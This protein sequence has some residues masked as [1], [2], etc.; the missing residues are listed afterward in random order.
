MFKS[1]YEVRL[2]C[3]NLVKG[4]PSI[5][6][7]TI[8]LSNLDRIFNHLVGDAVL[9]GVSEGITVDVTEVRQTVY[10]VLAECTKIGVSVTPENCDKLVN[11]VTKDLV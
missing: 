7:P 9:P 2:E 5:V 1:L 4:A 8:D 11:W 10:R 3:L 6:G